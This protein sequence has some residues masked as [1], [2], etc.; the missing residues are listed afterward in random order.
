MVLVF[1]QRVESK[2]LRLWFDETAYIILNNQRQTNN[3]VLRCLHRRFTMPESPIPSS[4]K[5]AQE[6]V[7]SSFE[8]SDMGDNPDS[9]FMLPPC[10][11]HPKNGTNPELSNALVHL[12]MANHMNSHLLVSG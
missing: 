1:S 5:N 7:A 11:D 3:F 6:I 8:S 4:T 12:E 10:P 2:S 9:G